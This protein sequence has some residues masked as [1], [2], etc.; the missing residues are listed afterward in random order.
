[1]REVTKTL[2][3]WDSQL[4]KWDSR[5]TK[6]KLKIQLKQWS[7]IKTNKRIFEKMLERIKYKIKCN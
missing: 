1:M 2:R 4:I 3:K 7:L 6:E 5:K